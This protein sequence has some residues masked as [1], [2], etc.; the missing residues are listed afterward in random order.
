MKKQITLATTVFAMIFAIS[1]V[2][3]IGFTSPNPQNIE[4]TPGQASYFTFQ[5]QADKD[6]G[7]I[8][9]PTVQDTNGLELAFNQEYTV[10]AGQRYNV[11]P[12]VIVPKQ[13]PFGNYKATFCIECEPSEDVEGSRIIPGICDMPVTVNV[14]GERTTG[15][16]LEPASAD[17][18]M[19]WVTLLAVAIVILAMV[20]FY[21]V[22]R[23]RV[24][25]ASL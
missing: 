13:T 2:S 17:Y 12:Q 25:A 8:C 16:L 24:S 3:A 21:L 6:F 7:I 5:I 14:V 4:L 23:R 11:K 19:I 9:V 18:F 1:I 20:I 15:N 10:E 22:R